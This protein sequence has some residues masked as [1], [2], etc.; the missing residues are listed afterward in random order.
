MPYL[1]SDFSPIPGYEGLYEIS[2][3]GIVRSVDRTIQVGSY[4]RFVPGKIKVQNKNKNYNVVWLYDKNH[5][6][7][8]WTV[9][10]LVALTFIPN[11]DI[12]KTQVNHKDGNKRN[13]NVA[14]LE[15]VT[16]KEN[17]THAIKSGLRNTEGDNNPANVIPRNI[18]IDI[19]K[20]KR[21]GYTMK[22]V[23]NKYSQY[24]YGTVYDCFKD[25]NWLCLLTNKGEVVDE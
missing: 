20:M 9:H 13:N 4:Y 19:K 11:D 12:T 17:T 25:R 1:K 10:R 15:W 7:K 21:A 2:K 14:N 22:E 8:E 3:S 24:K 18:A 5:I 6:G 16:P 23:H